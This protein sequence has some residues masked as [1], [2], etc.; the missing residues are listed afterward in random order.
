MLSAG[1]LSGSFR[2]GFSLCFSFW[3]RFFRPWE[4]RCATFSHGGS[5]KSQICASWR[6]QTTTSAANRVTKWIFPPPLSSV[7]GPLF[8]T[9]PFF[10]ELRDFMKIELPSRPELDFDGPRSLKILLFLLWSLSNFLSR[11]YEFE[12]VFYTFLMFSGSPPLDYD[13]LLCF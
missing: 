5:I 2:A 7:F 3:D 9:F 8:G 12:N 4:G 13:V 1:S 10:A 11:M 6:H